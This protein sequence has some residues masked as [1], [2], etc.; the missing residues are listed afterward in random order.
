VGLFFSGHGRVALEGDFPGGDCLGANHD[1]G[2]PVL[3]EV[4]GIVY[5]VSAA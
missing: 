3:P 2:L 4:V 5:T 1:G